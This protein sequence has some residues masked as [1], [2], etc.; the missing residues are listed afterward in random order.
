MSES[1]EGGWFALGAFLG[2]SIGAAIGLLYAPR[3][4]AET[5]RSLTEKSEGLRERAAGAGSEMAE[6]TGS[7]DEVGLPHTGPAAGAGAEPEAPDSS[8]IAVGPSSAGAMQTGTEQEVADDDA[9]EAR[10]A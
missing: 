3:P 5:R 6:G 7:A 8:E 1:K 10:D 2:A 9:G 4:G